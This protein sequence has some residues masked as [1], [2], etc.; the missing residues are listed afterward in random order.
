MDKIL[1]KAKD[2][3]NPI[4]CLQLKQEAIDKRELIL[5]LRPINQWQASLNR[6]VALAHSIE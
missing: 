4:N 1:A 3:N 6:N 2:A 5:K